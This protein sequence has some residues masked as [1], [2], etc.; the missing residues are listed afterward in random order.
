M[1]S[2][3]AMLQRQAADATTSKTLGLHLVFQNRTA[4]GRH[5]YLVL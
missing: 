5:A 4:P 1:N 2:P 3:H